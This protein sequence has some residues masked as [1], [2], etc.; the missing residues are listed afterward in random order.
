M[1][2]K[3]PQRREIRKPKAAFRWKPG[4]PVKIQGN[5]KLRATVLGP[6]QRK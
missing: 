6:A 3:I 4:Q 2:G 1:P 5:P